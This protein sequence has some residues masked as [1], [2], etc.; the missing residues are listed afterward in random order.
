MLFQLLS[1]LQLIPTFL[2]SAASKSTSNPATSAPV[3]SSWANLVGNKDSNS[4]E[5]TRDE[6]KA[7]PVESVL[8]VDNEELNTVKE[9]PDAPVNETISVDNNQKTV[10]ASEDTS[11]E[12]CSESNLESVPSTQSS[13]ITTSCT[14]QPKDAATCQVDSCSNPPSQNADVDKSDVEVIDK[15]NDIPEPDN[16]PDDTQGL[17]FNLDKNIAERTDLANSTDQDSNGNSVNVDVNKNF[18]EMTIEEIVSC[19]DPDTR[20]YD[21]DILLQ[22]QKHP[23]SLQKPDKLPELEIVRDAPLRSSSSAPL[24]GDKPP[25]YV[26]N[27]PRQ[28]PPPKRDSRRKES[29][30]KV[31]SLSREPVKLHK[32]EN[33]WTPGSKGGVEQQSELDDVLK[34]VRAILNKLTPQKFD[35]LV[36]KFKEIRIDTEEKLVQCM[37]LVFD[38]ALDEPAF[39]KAYASMCRELFLK[40]V[41]SVDFS[42]LLLRRCQKEFDQDYMS[43]SVKE[44]YEKDLAAAETEDDQKRIKAEFEQLETKLRRRSLGNIKFIA[45]LYKLQLLRHR[46]M[47]SIIQ[48]LLLSK[49]EEGLECLCQLLTTCGS[50][51]E[52][53]VEKIPLEHRSGYK[54]DKYFDGIGRIINDKKCSSR[55]RFLLQD[56]VDLRNNKWV[57]RRKEAGPKTIEEI[58]KEAKLEALKIQLAD[59]NPDPPPGRR[60]EDRNRRKTEYRPK[61]RQDEGWSNVPTRAAKISDIVDPERFR[62]IQKVDADLLQ[63]GPGFGQRTWGAGSSANRPA[64]PSRS[65]NRFQMLDVEHSVPPIYAGRA[66]EPVLNTA[67]RARTRD[68]PSSSDASRDQSLEFPHT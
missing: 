45:E 54:F 17:V 25:Q 42:N 14:E 46:I 20:Q 48:R 64:E 38:K 58:H 67:Q 10:L 52:A 3:K 23:L 18:T 4:L 29:S 12:I 40:K 59:Q 9:I 35:T 68:K 22:L 62:Q 28:G 49:E 60:N 33:A 16:K 53:E 39:S 50:Q 61:P 32:A 34:K 55:V 24:L 7:E 41:D 37:E 30:K 6:I 47:H 2:V 31:I 26:H 44:K 11:K 51:I 65:I 63:L 8:K 56:V 1:C 21:R 66:S 43:D 19:I 27:F 36:V 13:D 5:E 15:E 57:S